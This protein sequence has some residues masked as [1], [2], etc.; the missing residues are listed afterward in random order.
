[1]IAESVLILDSHFA[2]TNDGQ[3]IVEGL[4]KVPKTLPAKYFYDNRGSQ[5]FEQICQLQEYYP[6]RVET[7]ILNGCAD[8][9]A[10]ITG[11]VELVEL[12]SGSSTKSRILL[13]SYQKKSQYCRYLPVDVSSGILSSS[14]AK[15]ELQYPGF[16]IQGLA[17][18]YEQALNFLKSHKQ[19]RRLIFFLGSSLGNFDEHQSDLFLEQISNT[20]NPGDYFLLGVD[21]H[22]SLEILEAAYNDKQRVTEAFNLNM[23]SHINQ[24]FRAN[25]NLSLFTHQAIYNQAQH[26]IEMYLC[27]TQDQHICLA[28]LDFE[29]DLQKNERILTEISRKYDLLDMQ[30]KLQKHQ[31]KPLRTWSDPQQWFALILAQR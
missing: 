15:L 26:Q 28:G 8:E 22:K 24:R 25:F 18:S 12:G 27:S 4:G 16:F 1:M 30:N 23:L 5:L 11:I 17:G 9:I 10:Q 14:V 6:T 21:L 19:T 29:V 20:L 13:D 2:Q 31:I 3:D 7:E